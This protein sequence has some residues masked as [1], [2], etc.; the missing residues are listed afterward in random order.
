MASSLPQSGPPTTSAAH[1]APPPRRAGPLVF[2]D[3]FRRH[4]LNPAKW[5]DFITSAAAQGQPWNSNGAGGSAPAGRVAVTDLEYDLPQQV[6]IG[7]GLQIRAQRQSTSEVVDGHAVTFPWRSGAVSTYGKFEFDGGYLSVRAKMPTAP[8]MWPGVFL[9]PGYSQAGQPDT[10]EIDLFEGGYT[11]Q[12]PSADNYAWHLHTPQ[13]IVG[14]V[15]DVG[16]DLSSGF[17]TY[18]LDWVPGQSITWYFDGHEVGKVTS[19]QMTIPNEPME[20]VVDLQVAAPG[21]SSFH[22]LPGPTTP[23]SSTLVVQQMAVHSRE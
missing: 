19:A 20:V 2:S 23:P 4:G 6:T 12:G 11:G 5:D 16:T 3:A 10:E 7:D 18:A 13:G 15:T 14:G 1:A 17:H 9:L 22:T 21:T 8:G